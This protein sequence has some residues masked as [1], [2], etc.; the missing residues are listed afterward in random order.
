MPQDIWAR[1]Y[2]ERLQGRSLPM[3]AA[4]GGR[5]T[6]M[7]VTTIP[8][9]RLTAVLIGVTGIIIQRLTMTTTLEPM[10]GKPALMALT[11]RRLP[12]LVTIRIPGRTLEERPSRRLTAA[13]A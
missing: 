6:V 8:T 7:G 9:L 11:A 13:E 3:G 4:I 1:S 2:W 12:V 10:A 5:P